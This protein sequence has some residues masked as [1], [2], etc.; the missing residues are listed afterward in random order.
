VVS[1]RGGLGGGSKGGGGKKE[2]NKAKRLTGMW[3]SSRLVGTRSNSGHE[4]RGS[5]IYGMIKG[6]ES[7]G[8]DK[9][10]E[11]KI[12]FEQG[13]SRGR[14]GIGGGKAV[15][16]KLVENSASSPEADDEDEGGGGPP[17]GRG[18]ERYYPG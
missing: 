14:E 8:G 5:H 9:K 11:W 18:R 4:R 15:L 2:G 17:K 1:K 3:V 10:E 7:Q 16:G 13:K 6:E 12:C